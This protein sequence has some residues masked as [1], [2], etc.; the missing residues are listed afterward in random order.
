MLQLPLP[1]RCLK[2]LCRTVLRCARPT[3]MPCCPKRVRRMSQFGTTCIRML[4]NLFGLSSSRRRW[5]LNIHSPRLEAFF[6]QAWIRPATEPSSPATAT[7]A[8]SN[9]WSK[10]DLRRSKR[11]TL[12]PT[13]E[14]STWES[15]TILVLL[16]QASRQT[17]WCLRARSE[18]HT[19]ELQSRRDL[20]CRLLLE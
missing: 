17:S 18:E 6:L 19:S 2:G 3:S 12:Q 13:T 14:R 7:S 16:S 9:C 5:S 15:W 8:R 10:Q 1:Y 4:R 20:V 11:F